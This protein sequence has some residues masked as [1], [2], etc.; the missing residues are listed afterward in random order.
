MPLVT[1]QTHHQVPGTPPGC[2]PGTAAP[3]CRQCPT[4]PA[5][6]L[7]Q[8]QPASEGLP[9]Q[10]RQKQK[11]QQQQ[12]QRQLP[13]HHWHRRRSS[14]AAG[15]CLTAPASDPAGVRGSCRR[16]RSRPRRRLPGAARAPWPPQRR[17]TARA[18]VSRVRACPGAAPPS[19]T[20]APVHAPP[21]AA[22][23]TTR[24]VSPSPPGPQLRLCAARASGE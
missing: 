11:K 1:L 12:R 10:R 18:V 20:P 4:P 2:P 9:G 6:A 5:A 21:T 7:Q 15:T 3:P 16:F 22:Q 19:H 14:A 13:W 8:P 24:S 17:A 23:Q